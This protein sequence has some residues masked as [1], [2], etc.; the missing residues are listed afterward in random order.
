LVSTLA[1]AAGVGV[2]LLLPHTER[3]DELMGE[4]RDRL[5][6]TAKG[7]AHE[8]ADATKDAAQS[9]GSSLTGAS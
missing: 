4:A 3:E 6:E 8:L 5:L 1:L 9:V 2:G 7:A